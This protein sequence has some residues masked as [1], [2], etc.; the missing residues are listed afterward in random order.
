MDCIMESL[1]CNLLFTKFLSHSTVLV[2]FITVRFLLIENRKMLRFFYFFSKRRASNYASPSSWKA[3][4]DRRLTTN[5]EL[6]VEIFVC[7]HVSIWGFQNRVCLY[8]EKRNHPGFVNIRLTLVIGTSMERSSRELQHGTPKIWFLFFK[9]NFDLCWRAE[10][11][12]QIARSQYLH[13]IGDASFP[14]RD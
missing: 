14:L 9:F 8:H 10:I 1:P 11:N 2:W 12:I 4:S 13:D 6:W 5:F 7:R 3:Y